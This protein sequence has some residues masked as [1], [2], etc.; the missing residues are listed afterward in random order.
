MDEYTAFVNKFKP[1]KTTDDC[2]TPEN[3]FQVVQDWVVKEYGLDPEKFVRPFW[4]GG[5]YEIFDYPDDCVVVDNPPFSILSKICAFYRSHE[6]RYFLF[7]PALTALGTA[8][9]TG[10]TIIGAGCAITY[11]NGATVNTSF[12]TNLDKSVAR[13][14]PDLFKLVTKADNDNRAKSKK[15]VGNYAY[16]DEVLTAAMLN[17]LSVHDTDL[18]INREDV[19]FIRSLEEM[20]AQGKA[21]FGGGYLLTEKAAAEKA[22]ATR[23]KLSYSERLIVERNRLKEEAKE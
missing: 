19:F 18:K 23:W 7:A 12:L 14:A 6:I 16:P 17:K 10:A 3:V 11:E 9:T 4:P 22:A 20:K 1:K 15:E 2:Y 8:A 21:I 5:D 13:S